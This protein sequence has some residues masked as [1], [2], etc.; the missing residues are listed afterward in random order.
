M[1]IY[2]IYKFGYH[3]MIY[4]NHSRSNGSSS[5]SENSSSRSATRGTNG[6]TR[7]TVVVQT[8]AAFTRS[9]LDAIRRFSKK[10][11]HGVSI[12]AVGSQSDEETLELI[13]T[14]GRQSDAFALLGKN[15]EL[16]KAALLELRC[17]G[18]PVI[19]LVS[20]LDAS[21][22]STYIGG[23]NRAAGQLAGFIFG[24]SLER[25]SGAQVAMVTCNLAYR[26]WEDRQIGFHSLLRQRFPQINIVEAVAESDSPQAICEASLRVLSNGC[27]VGGIYNLVGGDLGLAQAITEI[28]LPRRPLYITHQLDEATEP[29]LRAGV[30]DF[31]IT[32][33]LE[34]IVNAAKRFVV[35]LRTGA[36]RSGEVNLIPIELIS[37]FNL[38]SRTVF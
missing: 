30:I 33:N 19:A 4:H 24:R 25:E 7:C 23:D 36:A 21:V 10:G 8:N 17:L 35:G 9:V 28:L 32:D 12:H 16:V 29:L 18:I 26:C 1:M 31:L 34:S 38:Q 13:G 5:R 15:N 14:A 20:D 37:K 22:R 3:L 2:D 11:S 27:A 6:A